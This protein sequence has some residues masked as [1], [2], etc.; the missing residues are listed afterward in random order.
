M[1]KSKVVSRTDIIMADGKDISRTANPVSWRYQAVDFGV[2]NWFT[3]MLDSSRFVV[4]K[5]P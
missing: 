2:F 5:W 1:S 3:V 4:S